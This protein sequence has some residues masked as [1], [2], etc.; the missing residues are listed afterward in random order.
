M[1][2]QKELW[3]LLLITCSIISEKTN[4]MFYVQLNSFYIDDFRAAV[5]AAF[6]SC[7]I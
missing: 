7:L 2:S 1:S 4:Y 6:L 5:S 3:E